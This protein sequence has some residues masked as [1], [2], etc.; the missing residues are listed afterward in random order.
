VKIA[1]FCFAR[2]T[3]LRR[4]ISL[5]TK[6]VCQK[7]PVRETFKQPLSVKLSGKGNRMCLTCRGT[8]P[9]ASFGC[10]DCQLKQMEQMSLKKRRGDPKEVGYHTRCR[11]IRGEKKLKSVP[12]RDVS[13]VR[14][15]ETKMHQQN[16]GFV[17]IPNVLNQDECEEVLKWMNGSRSK[18]VQ[19]GITEG[20]NR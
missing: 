6:M 18:K 17:K 13:L 8:F 4:L 2:H 14:T 15:L 1:N 5:G 10:S 20:D 11:Q 3:T 9:K 19:I 7:K 12:N 16:K